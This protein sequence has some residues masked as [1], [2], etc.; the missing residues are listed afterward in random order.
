MPIEK[1]KRI[2]VEKIILSS[3]YAAGI[4]SLAIAV[5]NSAKLIGGFGLRK[6]DPKHAA[7]RA[8]D[9]LILK[10][11]LKIS[12]EEGERRIEL[13]K[14][15][16]QA[17]DFCQR[18]G[19]KSKQPKSW[20]EKWRVI[21]FDIPERRKR[22]REQVRFTLKQIGFIRLQQSVWIYPYPCEELIS[23]L[24]VDFQIGKNLLYLVVESLEGDFRIRKAFGLL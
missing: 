4:L 17:L 5:P 24:K 1:Q 20:D 3:I 16:Q 8:I 21:I 14:K 9:N 18:H 11:M 2:N 15:G 10:G 19:F 23:L 12:F 7:K 22:V 13:T 6:K